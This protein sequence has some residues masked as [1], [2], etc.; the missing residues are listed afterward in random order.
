LPSGIRIKVLPAPYFIATKIE[1][2][3]QRGAGDFLLSR[4]VEDVVAVL[5]GREE[6]VKEA[7]LAETELLGNIREQLRQ[8]IGNRDFLDAL[9]GLLP[10][11]VASQARVSIILERIKMIIEQ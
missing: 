1:A 10:P 11:D 9:P 4:D 2:F 8:W 3:H 7:K 5:D 6:I